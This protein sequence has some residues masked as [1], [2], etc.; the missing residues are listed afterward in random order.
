MSVAA[1]QLSSA[2]WLLSIMVLACVVLTLAAKRDY[3]ETLGVDRK[4]TQH[5]IKKAFRKLAAKYHPDKN[6][7]PGAEEKFK[8]VN[9]G[10]YKH[11]LLTLTQLSYISLQSV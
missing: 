9:D 10:L 8:E 3:Y 4:A 6:K 11:V 5:Q 7:D 2:A 1:M